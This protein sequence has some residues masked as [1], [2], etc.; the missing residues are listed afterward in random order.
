M[1]FRVYLLI[2]QQSLQNKHSPYKAVASLAIN[3][4]YWPEADIDSTCVTWFLGWVIQR[5]IPNEIARS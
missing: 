5:K 4:R 2:L 1:T 3:V